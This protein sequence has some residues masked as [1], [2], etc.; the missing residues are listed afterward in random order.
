MPIAVNGINRSGH[1]MLPTTIILFSAAGTGARHSVAT[2][3]RDLSFVADA[4]DRCSKRKV[5]VT[6][7]TCVVVHV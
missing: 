4:N 6:V 3:N 2:I 1:L 5:P 7:N